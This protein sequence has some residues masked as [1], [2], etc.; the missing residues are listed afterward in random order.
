MM[1]PRKKL[2]M[3]PRQVLTWSSGP[4]KGLAGGGLK[5]GLSLTSHFVGL[6]HGNKERKRISYAFVGSYIPPELCAIW[7]MWNSSDKGGKIAK[8]PG[9]KTAQ[10]STHWGSPSSIFPSCVFC[11]H[12]VFTFSHP[13]SSLKYCQQASDNEFHVWANKSWLENV[14]RQGLS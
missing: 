8:G 12:F 10:P 7:Q 14:L 2:R 6:K 4:P 13:L 5:K 9:K 3:D 11:Q 1:L